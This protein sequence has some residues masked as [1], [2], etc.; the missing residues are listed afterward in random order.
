MSYLT[1]QTDTAIDITFDVILSG[2]TFEYSLDTINWST[3][4][5]NTPIHVAS[6]LYVRGV[7]NENLTGQLLHYTIPNDTSHHTWSGNVESL[8]DYTVVD[9]GN[10]PVLSYLCLYQLCKDDIGLINVDNLEFPTEVLSQACY[11]EMFSGCSNLVSA[12]F[13]LPSQTLAVGCYQGMFLNC[14]SLTIGPVALPALTLTPGCYCDMFSGTALT[15]AYDIPAEVLANQCCQRMYKNCTRLTVARIPTEVT[16]P[17]ITA[18][19][20]YREM[21][22]GCTSLV[23]P[24]ALPATEIRSPADG[25]YRAM[26]KDCTALTT[27]PDLP[28]T[29]IWTEAYYEMFSG[30][31]SLVNTP[32]SIGDNAYSVGQY[33]FYRMF[34]GC[35]AL[36]KA[37]NIGITTMIYAYACYQMFSGCSSLKK[38]AKFD[39]TIN[40]IYQYG[41]YGMYT[42]CISLVE[43]PELPAA[44]VM[45]YGYRYMFQGC[46]SL[47]DL[48]DLPDPT[49]S[50]Y[51]YNG[52]FYGCSSIK[53]STAQTGEYQ[54]PYRIPSGTAT[55]TSATAALTNM[56]T[57]TGGTFTGTPVINTT[58]YLAVE[59]PASKPMYVGVNSKAREV[60]D[61]Y[62]GVNSKA[63]K[64]TAIY[65]GVNG[66]AREVY[67]ST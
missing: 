41:C 67:K 33:G 29:T 27:M 11:Y 65:V 17:W 57:D 54:K 48:P 22:M 60:T 44:T 59:I 40:N 19:E 7:G 49:L 52:M 12:H 50:N 61:M 26:F 5:I 55:G 58:Y 3:I 24:C 51:C 25:A 37:P 31:T 46:T 21:F 43:P 34:R 47:K 63:R 14:S 35:T 28:A 42:N 16:S 15:E 62:V 23:T 4:V 56:F 2:A 8:I 39:S 6:V 32:N 38:A 13:A 9:G 30:C 66:K 36:K 20:V 45:Q 53:L 18:K 64:V 1:L 10:S